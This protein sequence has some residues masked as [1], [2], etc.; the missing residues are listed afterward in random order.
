M[1]TPEAKR[2]ILEEQ[3]MVRRKQQEYQ[4]YQ[5]KLLEQQ[6]K[7]SEVEKW[8][9]YFLAYDK[10]RR[11]KPFFLGLNPSKDDVRMYNE[12]RKAMLGQNS[13]VP[14]HVLN[15]F[16]GGMTKSFSSSPSVFG[17][18]V[19]QK[20]T[21]TT[22]D[23]EGEVIKFEEY[24]KILED[25]KPVI[26]Y[27]RTDYSYKEQPQTSITKQST[28]KPT[29]GVIITPGT[30]RTSS[31]TSVG[32]GR[33]GGRGGGSVSLSSIKIP[34]VIKDNIQKVINTG[35]DLV[36]VVSGGSIEENRINRLQVEQN[37]RIEKFNQKYGWEELDENTYNQALR[38]LE[39]L[40]EA[41][42]VIDNRWNNFI[43]STANKVN[44]FYKTFN[45]N[46]FYGADKRL[47]TEQQKELEEA[48]KIDQVFQERLQQNIPIIQK[49]QEDNLKKE[50][51][52][53][54]LNMRNPIDWIQG[55]R[56]QNR[57]DNNNKNINTLLQGRKIVVMP[58]PLPFTIKNYMP[59][60]QI[61][62]VSFLA[63]GKKLPNGAYLSTVLYK[64][65]KGGIGIGVNV[66]VKVSNGKV[67]SFGASRIGKIVV[68]PLSKHIKIVNWRTILTGSKGISKSKG[69]TLSQLRSASKFKKITTPFFESAKKL[70]A[71]QTAGIGRSIAKKEK[72]FDFSKLILRIT[73]KLKK[74]R[75]SIQ[76]FAYIVNNIPKGRLNYIAG[77]T[78]T[79]TGRRAEFVGILKNWAK[80]GGGSGIKITST[81][82]QL[83]EYTKALE[84]T[85][86]SITN[87]FSKM[88]QK[89]FLTQSA[90]IGATIQSLG[91]KIPK[92]LATKIKLEEPTKVSSI[93]KVIDKPKPSTRTA[94]DS[95]TGVQTLTKNKQEIR[96]VQK[97]IVS[98]QSKINQL[99]NTLSKTRSRTQQRQ[100]V[101]QLARIRAKQR[102]LLN[103]LSRL[104]TQQKQLLKMKTL[105]KIV[106]TPTGEITFGGF[107]FNIDK[108]KFKKITLKKSVM[109]YYVLIKRNNR[110][111]KTTP[112]PFELSGAKDYL[113]YLIDHSLSK[114]AFIVPDG[115]TKSIY[116]LPKTQQ[117]YYQKA[118][119]KLR[120]YRIR[121]GKK[122]QLINGFI[123][124]RK[125]GLDTASEKR[126]LKY[127]K[128]TSRP[129]R[130][131]T[132]RKITP[133]QRRILL[134]RLEKARAVRMR[135]LRKK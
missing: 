86:A 42:N 16:K 59:I 6:Q 1:L 80:K 23:K 108:D 88:E 55:I 47:T 40:N 91:G 132:K 31:P 9:N 95:T 81:N 49:Y 89:Q 26:Q 36:N 57:I 21:I 60:N 43:T 97:Q 111:I 28:T 98:N 135:N 27:S 29:Q 129:T 128:I 120:P 103:Q 17:L 72:V 106:T 48:R 119:H 115:K 7:Q 15:H 66:A 76:N 130:K 133:A 102:Q 56:L 44:D 11:G 134:K 113:A 12:V 87:A 4:Q 99:N 30:N 20:S 78:I 3:A 110:L 121:Y 5:Q 18:D 70:K 35:T 10:Q 19:G 79:T 34:S 124:K 104:K 116:V 122:K 71:V 107:Y 94:V 13:S 82:K 58:E 73:P 77:K 54:N 65:N 67:V 41:Q 61:S 84:E 33:G 53:N 93:S 51:Q 2:R 8:G 74:L 25:K 114:T 85:V 46:L 90:V 92:T 50:R 100:I 118:S 62:K 52:L 64:T 127:S 75:L 22:K 125:Y 32:G 45:K 38:E 131:T 117:N 96:S 24:K 101:N 112:R 109:G 14:T 69:L 39:F 126:E 83:S 105:T 63:Q 37:K 68:S 123:E